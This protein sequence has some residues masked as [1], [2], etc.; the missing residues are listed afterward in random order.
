M[1]GRGMDRRSPERT[2][3]L[4]TRML[5]QPTKPPRRTQSPTRRDLEFGDGCRHRDPA[6]GRAGDDAATHGHG[7]MADGGSAPEPA[8]AAGGDAASVES[9]PLADRRRLLLHPRLS[10][11]DRASGRERPCAPGDR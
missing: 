11:D 9:G 5:A 2:G 7:A 4:T 3:A 6:A 8:A 10:A 1:S